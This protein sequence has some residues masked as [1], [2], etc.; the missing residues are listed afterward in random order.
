MRR[1]R[2]AQRWV[3]YYTSRFRSGDHR[4]SLDR[5]PLVSAA[6]KRRHEASHR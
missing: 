2:H 1:I 4:G 3:H 5:P 6:G